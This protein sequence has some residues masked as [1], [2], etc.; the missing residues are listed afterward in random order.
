[1]QKIKQHKF[2]FAILGVLLLLFFS[3]CISFFVSSV[4]ATTN[5]TIENSGSRLNAKSDSTPTSY[6][7]LISD[8]V[9]GTYSP[10]DGANQKYYDIKTED[11]GKYIKVSADGS[12]SETVGPIGKLIVMDME[13][14]L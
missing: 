13:W 11:E 6:Q 10:I 4:G 7:W 3:I 14:I 8:T 9:E 5:V 1:M 12:E 2:T